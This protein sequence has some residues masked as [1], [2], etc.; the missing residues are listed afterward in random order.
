MHVVGGNPVPELESDLSIPIRFLVYTCHLLEYDDL[1]ITSMGDGKEALLQLVFVTR[2][3][4]GASAGKVGDK[5]SWDKYIFWSL[6]STLS[7]DDDALILARN[8]DKGSFS[9]GV[10][11]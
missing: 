4:I 2:A 3:P 11:P 1:R 5:Q 10:S 8:I 9:F 7:L 6:E